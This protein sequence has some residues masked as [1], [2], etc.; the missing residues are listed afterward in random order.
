MSRRNRIRTH[1]KFSSG[2]AAQQAA[3]AAL[4]TEW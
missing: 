4:R 3:K 1:S 2:E